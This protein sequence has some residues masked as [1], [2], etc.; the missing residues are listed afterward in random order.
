VGVTIL[1]SSFEERKL[2]LFGL[3]CGRKDVRR[4]KAVRSS[5]GLALRIEESILLSEELSM[6]T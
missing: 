3:P 5:E 6:P 2:N 4:K 1:V